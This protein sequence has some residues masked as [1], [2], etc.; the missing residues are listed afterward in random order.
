[1]LP[2]RIKRETVER[3]KTKLPESRDARF[4]RY[5]SKYNLPTNDAEILS[6]SKVISD[7][8][9]ECVS[10]LPEYKE[11]ANWILVDIL[12]LDFD[13]VVPISV[14]NLVEIVKMVLGKR[15]TRQNGKELLVSVIK[16]GK[17]AKN[18]ANAMGIISSV[19][20]GEI[21]K[22][23]DELVDSDKKARA[24]YA[25]SPDKVMQYFIG[26]VMRLTGGRA[27]GMIVREVLEKKLK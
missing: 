1:M 27:D 6:N 20:R 3:L 10:I 15:I 16:T 9:D 11:I 22:I 7:F 24:D 14:D 19:S 4:N 21:E 26:G 5:I 8:Y 25:T 12:K 18:L 17:N 2:I 13:E 23:V